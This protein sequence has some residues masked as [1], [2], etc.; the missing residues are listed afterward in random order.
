LIPDHRR[1]AVFDLVIANG[2]VVLE[3]RWH[4]ASH[5]T[6]NQAAAPAGATSDLV[7]DGATTTG[8]DA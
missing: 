7:T 3:D 1:L 2:K 4:D 5:R 8:L 6:T